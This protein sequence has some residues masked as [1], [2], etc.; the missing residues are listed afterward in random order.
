[1]K[2]VLFCGG[3]GM[4]IRE[5][6]ES[7]PKPMVHV[8]DRPIL[9]HVMKYYAHFGHKDFILCLGYRADAIKNYFV[10]YNEFMSN[11]F[12][13]SNGGKDLRVFN[14][15]IHDWTITFVNTGVNANLGQRLKAVEKYVDGEEAF[16]ANYSDNVTD[17]HLPNLIDCFREQNKTAAFLCVKPNLTCHYVSMGDGG[18]VEEIRTMGQSEILINGGYFVFKRSI[19][20]YI[21]DGEELVQEPFRRL[22]EEKNLIGYPY[23]GFWKSMDTFK[24]KQELD[25]L[26]SRNCAPW[27]LWKQQ[28]NGGVAIRRE[29]SGPKIILPEQSVRAT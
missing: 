20:D 24:E 1:M 16:L 28:N 27:Q 19:F 25:D 14:S 11:D 23:H 17:F 21:K 26:C 18:L 6:S 10:N 3:L 8:G 5:A 4:R 29:S 9:W 13:L 15:D 22:I 2:V 7:V 12:V